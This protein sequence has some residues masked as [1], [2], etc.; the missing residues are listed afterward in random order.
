MLRD[1]DLFPAVTG[2][3]QVEI[4]DNG[5]GFPVASVI[6]TG[7]GL[8]NMKERAQQIK[9]TAHFRSEP[10]KGTSILLF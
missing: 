2:K 10:G 5:K 3:L 7:N 1:P 4:I 9:L 8:T 6:N